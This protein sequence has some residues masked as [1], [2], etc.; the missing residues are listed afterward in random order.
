VPSRSGPLRVGLTG[1]I[2]T[3]KSHV[4]AQF[5]KLGAPTIDSDVLARQAV[6]PGSPGLAAV[7]QTF[8]PDVLDPSGALDRRRLAAVVFADPAKRRALEAIV[9][10]FVQQ[11]TEAWY[12]ALGADVRFAIADIPLLYEIGRDRDVEVVVVTAVPPDV[13]ARRIV[14]RDGVTDAEAWQRIHAQL[15]IE[16]KIARADYVIRTD[17]SFQDTDRQVAE[18][19]EALSSRAAAG[20][21]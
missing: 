15:P 11:A 5:E 4:R 8:G 7:V 13:Q 19:F 3:G 10:P 2:A 12:D 21:R 16:E 6:V 18:V 20:G 1:G 17:G 14:A 9:H